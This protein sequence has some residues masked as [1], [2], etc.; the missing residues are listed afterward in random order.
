M[1]E[2]HSKE[3]E[4]AKESV[5]HK[6]QKARIC[7][8][9]ITILTKH[10]TIYK[11][12]LLCVTKEIGFPFR[13]FFPWSCLQRRVEFGPP[14]LTQKFAN[15]SNMELLQ[16]TILALLKRVVNTKKILISNFCIS[17]IGV[18]HL[19]WD[20]CRSWIMNFALLCYSELSYFWEC[21]SFL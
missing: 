8:N 3:T 14:Q 21:L 1:T 18:H 13:C 7:V 17:G 16:N 6:W 9:Q 12:L 11:M 2:S 19:K 15:I 5:L 20:T 4:T 10:N